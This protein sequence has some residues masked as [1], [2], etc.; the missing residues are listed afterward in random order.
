MSQHAPRQDRSKRT[1]EAILE[2]TEALLEER[3]FEEISIAEIIVKA[4]SSTGSFYARFSS[5]DALL[6]ALY[7]R[8]H[9]GLPERVAEI[10]RGLARKAQSLDVLC[11]HIVDAFA[12]S[13]EGRRVNLMRAMS[14]YARARSDEIRDLARQRTGLHEELVGLFEPYRAQIRHTDWRHAVRTALFIAGTSVREALL[15]PG[16]PFAAAT[17]QPA[18]RFKAAAAD[19]LFSY[20]T[21]APRR[22]E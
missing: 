12:T 8:Y 2:A 3:S 6:P 9:A 5:K 10:R 22:P 14:M 17:R 11:S 15:F 13:F 19:M 20:L 4:G 1:L 7:E 21:Q 18:N 16:A